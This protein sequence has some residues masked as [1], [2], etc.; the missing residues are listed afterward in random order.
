MVYPGNSGIDPKT[1]PFKAVGEPVEVPA[2]VWVKM[3]LVGR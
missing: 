2:P 3:L 1:S